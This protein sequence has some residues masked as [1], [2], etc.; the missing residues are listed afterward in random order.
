MPLTTDRIRV[1]RRVVVGRVGAVVGGPDHDRVI[2]DA[3]LLELVEDLAGEVVHLGQDVG[4]VPTLGLAHVEFDY[5]VGAEQALQLA[6][7]NGWTV[8]SIKDDWTTV[9]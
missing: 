4:P 2:G 6:S 8:V 3:Q 5:V 1:D 7:T 9:F